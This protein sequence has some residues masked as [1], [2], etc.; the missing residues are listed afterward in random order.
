MSDIMPDLTN[1]LMAHSNIATSS[2]K[3]SQFQ[4]LSQNERY[5]VQREMVKL[6]FHSV[7]TVQHT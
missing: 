4:S 3:P 6:R 5:S 7:P 1:V 2:V